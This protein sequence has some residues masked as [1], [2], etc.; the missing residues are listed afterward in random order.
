MITTQSNKKQA[1]ETIKTQH[2]ISILPIIL[3]LVFIPLAIRGVTVN[4]YLSNYVWYSKA[5]KTADVFLYIKSILFLIL[6][7]SMLA[8]LVYYLLKPFTNHKKISLKKSLID[9]KCFIPLVIYLILIITSTIFSEYHTIAL[10]GFTSQYE[11][12]WVLLGYVLVAY[13]TYIFISNTQ[14]IKII[15]NALVVTIALIGSIGLSQFLGHDFFQTSFGMSLISKHELS[16]RFSEGHVYSTLYNPNYVGLYTSLVTP[17]MVVLIIYSKGMLK[18]VLYS[19]V[20]IV[21]H[22]SCYGSR[23]SSG[24]VGS[25]AG[26]VALVI[27]IASI[28][29]SLLAKYAKKILI[30]V[31]SL[32]IIVVVTNVIVGNPIG[33]KLNQFINTILHSNDTV[34]VNL[35]NIKTEDDEVML[36]YK[37]EE[38]HIQLFNSNGQ[39]TFKFTDT[40]KQELSYDVVNEG[41]YIV[42]QDP[43]FSELKISLAQFDDLIVFSVDIDGTPWCFTNEIDGTYYYFNNFGKL[44]KLNQES[45]A[46]KYW[47]FG[48]GRGYI[49][50]KTIPLIKE[51][52][53]FGTGPDSFAMY[54]PNTDYLNLYHAGFSNEIISKPH[55]I[56]LQIAAQTGIPS[57]IAFIAFFVMYVISSIRL[58]YKR[59]LK[60]Y[61]VQIA[62]GILTGTFGY[63]ISCLANDSTVTVAPVFWT[64]IGVGLS[65][66]KLIKKNA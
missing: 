7:G 42:L 50:E 6:S 38:L 41:A 52:P 46:K 66:N 59:S 62:V 4:T 2:F 37:G 5:T 17:L 11:S 45:T 49:W 3:V 48:S 43:R 65:I 21:L 24:I 47:S 60:D 1:K 30:G 44:L 20:T 57:L 19:L 15:I 26:V 55:S 34:A 33:N 31:I 32:F 12:F 13:Y 53:L 58:Y 63:M 29:R 54:F 22:I 9:E 18:K 14:Q 27:M 64:L 39:Y 40:S 51:H 56:Y 28:N 36:A 8:I 16:F 61:E 25:I 10:K 35:S 23:S